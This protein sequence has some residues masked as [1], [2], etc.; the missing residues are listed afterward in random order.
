MATVD[1]KTTTVYVNNI[2]AVDDT[3]DRVTV[4]PTEPGASPGLPGMS[5]YVF[6]CPRG[7]YKTGDAFS[8]VQTLSTP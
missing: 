3:T 2:A 1:T 8:Y 4:T 5:P 7:T 6:T